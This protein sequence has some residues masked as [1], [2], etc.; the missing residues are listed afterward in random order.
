MEPETKPLSLLQN[1]AATATK[2]ILESGLGQSAALAGIRLI[3]VQPEPDGQERAVL[4]TFQNE[5][6]PD[7]LGENDQQANVG[8]VA[9]TPGNGSDPKPS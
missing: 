5:E 4:V 8:P 7:G 9:G 3:A 2:A 6:K 1:I